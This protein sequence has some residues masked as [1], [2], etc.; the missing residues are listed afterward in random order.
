[1]V[2]CGDL[3]SVCKC[4]LLAP[5][6]QVL[7]HELCAF[8]LCFSLF[9]LR[10]TPNNENKWSKKRGLLRLIVRSQNSQ[11]RTMFSLRFR[12]NHLWP[13]GTDRLLRPGRGAGFR[14]GVQFSKRLNFEGK[15][16]K[17]TE[18]EGVEILR[19]RTGFLYKSCQTV[20]RLKQIHVSFKR[21]QKNA[22]WRF[23]VTNKM[24]SV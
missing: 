1:M 22:L 11:S 17:C 6:W 12:R 5:P 13:L 2:I 20:L 4:T 23:F 16:G 15:F 24:L 19:H 14:R 3:S 7:L 10:T 18:C 9:G 21:R 8:L